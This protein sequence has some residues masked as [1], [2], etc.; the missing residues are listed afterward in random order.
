M[1]NWNHI[2]CSRCWWNGPGIK[3]TEEGVAVRRPIR[4]TKSDLYLCCFCDLPT[5]DGIYVRRDPQ[6]AE[7]KCHP[8]DKD[9]HEP[10]VKWEDSEEKVA[11]YLNQ[12]GDDVERQRDER[13]AAQA[14]QGFEPEQIGEPMP[15]PLKEG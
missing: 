2:I 6:D 4:V 8:T 12:V 1:S 13:L 11:E 7:L 15:N 10:V 5:D 3:E 9:Y 14:E